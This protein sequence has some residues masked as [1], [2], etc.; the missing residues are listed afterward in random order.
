MQCT[1]I[2][3]CVRVRCVQIPACLF[4]QQCSV[5][6]ITRRFCTECRL[7]KCFAVGMK[8]S[9]IL[10]ILFYSMPFRASISPAS[11]NLMFSVLLDAAPAAGP[12]LHEHSVVIDLFLWT[13]ARAANE[14]CRNIIQELET[15]L[16]PA[17]R[18]QRCEAPTS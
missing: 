17:L 15:R 1:V 7:K 9:M 2:Q 10:G 11:L 8:A 13:P 5:Q 3:L 12:T 14:R 6:R 16:R 18:A 4:G